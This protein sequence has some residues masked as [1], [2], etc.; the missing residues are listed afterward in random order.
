M[1]VF[2]IVEFEYH[3]ERKDFFLLTRIVTI[4]IKGTK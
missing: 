3:R 4:I 1:G 2:H